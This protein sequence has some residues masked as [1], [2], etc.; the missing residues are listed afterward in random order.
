MLWK[1]MEERARACG[2]YIAQTG[3]TVRAC[4]ERFGVGKSTVHKDVTERLRAIDARLFCRVRRVLGINL[5]ERHLRGGAATRRKYKGA[6]PRAQGG[7][8]EKDAPRGVQDYFR[9]Q[10]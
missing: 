7:A 6:E 10:Y 2:E 1:D 3:C 5:R 4:A 9:E 8:A